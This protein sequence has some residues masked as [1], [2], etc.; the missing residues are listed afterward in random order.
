MKAQTTTKIATFP[1]AYVQATVS[2]IDNRNLNP[3]VVF[4]RRKRRLNNYLP[5]VADKQTR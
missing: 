3:A 5:S 1:T 4:V 2:I